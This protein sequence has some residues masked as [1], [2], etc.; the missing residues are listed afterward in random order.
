MP[1]KISDSETE[2]GRVSPMRKALA[3]GKERVAR[4]GG[5]IGCGHPGAIIRFETP[6]LLA[7][8]GVEQG[9]EGRALGPFGDGVLARELVQIDRLPDIE[10][11]CQRAQ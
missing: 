6:A 11:R 4:G 1:E 9:L 7:V 5:R 2:I 10:P 8:Q 3:E